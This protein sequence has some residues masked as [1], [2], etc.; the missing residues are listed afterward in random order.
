[1]CDLWAP[2]YLWYFL[3]SNWGPSQREM[4]GATCWR[5]QAVTSSW[6][7][8]SKHLWMLKDLSEVVAGLSQLGAGYLFQPS[9]FNPV[10]LLTCTIT[11]SFWFNCSVLSPSFFFYMVYDLLRDTCFHPL[12]LFF[13]LFFSVFCHVYI[14]DTHI[15]CV[16]AVFLKVPFSGLFTIVPYV[17]STT[18]TLAI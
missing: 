1:M 11:L 13:S 9:T 15:L 18:Q 10:Q 5:L 17:V 16:C 2:G 8:S 7:C 3:L 12:I 4:E 14:P 6:H